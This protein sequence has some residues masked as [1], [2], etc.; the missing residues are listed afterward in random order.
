MPEVLMTPQ[1]WANMAKLGSIHCT[2]DDHLQLLYRSRI[3]SDESSDKVNICTFCGEVEEAAGNTA[4]NYL[5][6]GFAIGKWA[7]ERAVPAF[8]FY[9][10]DG[11]PLTGAIIAGTREDVE[12][13][14]RQCTPDPDYEAE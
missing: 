13:Y 11:L 8:I 7:A 5:V 12:S 2:E 10:T 6:S 9:E 4:E 14:L 3:V 1:Q